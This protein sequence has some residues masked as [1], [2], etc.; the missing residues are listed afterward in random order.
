M[1]SGPR[2]IG[3]SAPLNEPAPAPDRHEAEHRDD[4]GQQERG[5]EQGHEQRPADE[6]APGE[7]AGGW[8]RERD[9][10]G[11]GDQRLGQ[12]EAHRRPVAGPE[13]ASGLGPQRQ[14]AERAER[15][16]RDE[17]EREAAAETDAEPGRYRLSARSHSSSAGSRWSRAASGD[18]RS[19]FSGTVSAAKP[20]GRP[21]SGRCAGYIQLVV[22]ITDWKPS[23]EHEVE[24]LRA[25]APAG[26]RR[27]SSRRPRSACSG[28][29]RRWRRACRRPLRRSGGR[30]ARWCR[31]SAMST[32]PSR[33]RP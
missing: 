20:S 2:P 7:R 28:P 33:N 1:S 21:A 19:G 8:D 4:R 11:G 31:L 18:S 10:E 25:Q 6:P 17:G 23:V 24:E 15:Q 9:G 26:R 12:R 27:R 14:G 3:A 30:R 16:R 5:A 22:G 13:P 32:S 29:R